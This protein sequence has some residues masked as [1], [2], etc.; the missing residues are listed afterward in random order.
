M[1]T[2]LLECF[3]RWAAGLSLSARGRAGAALGWLLGRLLRFRRRQVLAAMARCLPERTEKDRVAIADGMYRH[4]GR[5]VLEC[6]GFPRLPPE[7]FQGLVDIHG[8]D[9][10]RAAL[11]Q[12]RGALALM[13][14]IGNWELMGLAMAKHAPAV[15]VVVKTQRNQAFNDYWRASR[16]HMGLHMLPAKN[17]YRECLRALERGEIVAVT[18]DQNM[19]RHRGIFVDFFGQPACTT[20][21]L[22]HLAF[23]SKA[24]VIPIYSIRQPNGRHAVYILPALPPPPDREEAT[25]HAAT[26]AYTRILEDI[27][28]RHPDQWLWL[29]KRWRTR[30]DQPRRPAP[31][32]TDATV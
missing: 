24:P 10:G 22:A 12:G 31:R 16:Q 29:H 7:V 11:Q 15:N 28:R 19:R 17:S 25:I 5:M 3:S 18:L 30:P 6:L 26:Q 32:R 4:L 8:L 1:T 9:E 14:H 20:P 23:Q 13:G 2:W 27:I 21:G